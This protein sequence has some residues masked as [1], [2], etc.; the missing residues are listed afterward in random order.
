[1]TLKITYSADEDGYF[2]TALIGEHYVA[3]YA[4][5]V[6]AAEKKLIEKAKDFLL[7]LQQLPKPKE[8]QI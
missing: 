4:E 8:V 7:K 2:A 5:T 6:E 3:A 1:M